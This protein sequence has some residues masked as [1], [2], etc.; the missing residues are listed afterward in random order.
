MREQGWTL[1]ILIRYTLLQVPALALFIL[2]LILSRRWIEIPLW[3]FWGLVIV[4]LA[5][6]V[7]LFP[8]VWRAYDDR[9]RKGGEGMIGMQGIAQDRLAPEGYVQ[10][11]GELWRAELMGGGLPVE[12]G[13]AVKVRE[14]RGLTLLVQPCND[15]EDDPIG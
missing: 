10:I 11:R 13:A 1:R 7:I 12:E 2:T 4:W 5:K 8:F 3:S 6:D 14:T 15:E 9:E